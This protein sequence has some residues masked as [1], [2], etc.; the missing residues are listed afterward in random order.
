MPNAKLTVIIPTCNRAGV[1]LKTLSAYAQQTAREEILEIL[2]IDDGS[3]DE[4][5]KA[6]SQFADTCPIPVRHFRQEN[7]GPATARNR[8]IREAKGELVLLGDDDVIPV[9]TMVAEHLAWQARYPDPSIAI[10]GSIFCSPEVNPTPLMKWWGLNGLRFDPP[11][12]KAGHDVSW[13]A[14][15]FLNTSVKVTFLRENGLF[16]ERFRAYGYEDV[17]LGYRLV[18]KGFRM[19]YNPDA[20]GYHYKRI[21]FSDM[22]RRV[23]TMNTTPSLQIFSGTEA[24]V[25]Y[26]QNQERRRKS[27]RY[28]LQRKLTRMFVPLLSVL[29]P[30]L[31]S[32]VPLPGFVYAAFLAYHGSFESHRARE[33]S[34]VSTAKIG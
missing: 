13:A 2:V 9:P 31:D 22:C 1:L 5:S 16:D 30:L 15:L 17:E 21:S 20:M 6:V 7:Q 8:G 12:M 27:R 25:H 14:G 29:K 26:L 4:T 28:R 3:K 19:I 23:R 11:L 33:T 24:G 32:Q 10:V 18:R 34:E